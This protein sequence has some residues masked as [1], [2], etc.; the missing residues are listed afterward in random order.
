MNITL[1]DNNRLVR[2]VFRAGLNDFV[3][4][5]YVVYA[6]WKN[7]ATCINWKLLMKLNN[8]C[9]RQF[10]FVDRRIQRRCHMCHYPRFRVARWVVMKLKIKKRVGSSK[11]DRRISKINVA[12]KDRRP[13][14]SWNDRINR[15]YYTPVLMT[16]RRQCPSNCGKS[17]F[18][19][20]TGIVVPYL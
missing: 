2:S 3:C 6:G 9:D 17:T 15:Y 4:V 13:N 7:R 18:G 14:D 11:T 8:T 16:L 12:R 5:V 10:P 20:C 1:S 19:S